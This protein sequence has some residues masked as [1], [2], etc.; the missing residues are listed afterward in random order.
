M[1]PLNPEIIGHLNPTCDGEPIHHI[2]LGAFDFQLSYSK[3]RIQTMERAVFSIDGRTYDWQDGPSSIPVWLL[4]NQTP[5]SFE[6]A[7]QFALRMKLKSDDWVE[8]Y[9]DH[10]PYETLIIDFG[11]RDRAQVLEIF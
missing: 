10:S 3:F 11:M 4:I 8:F 1:R 6:L 5:E 7:T 2:G 9:C